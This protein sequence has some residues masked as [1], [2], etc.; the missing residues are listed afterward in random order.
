MSAW[1]RSKYPEWAVASWSSSGVIEPIE[2]F[3]QFDEQIYTSTVKSG[4]FCPKAIQDIT[5]YVTD[6]FKG[7]DQK[8]T[9]DILEVFD[10]KG[11][12]TDEFMF[13]FADIFVESVQYGGRRA[14]C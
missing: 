8:K 7:T 2:F 6:T 3:T 13:Y 5:K 11:M 4:A 9:N 1:F 10:A 14:L 12:R